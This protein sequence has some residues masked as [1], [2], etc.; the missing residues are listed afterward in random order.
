MDIYIMH[1]VSCLQ[2]AAHSVIFGVFLG[3][4]AEKKKLRRQAVC[5]LWA[6]LI[7]GNY[8]SAC[9]LSSALLLKQAAIILFTSFVMQYRF[10]QRFRRILA[11]MALYQAVNV[12]I[13]YL[14]L[15]LAGYYFPIFK[16]RMDYVWCGILLLQNLIV[17]CLVLAVKRFF[18]G[19][20]FAREKSLLTD[21]EWMFFSV[22]PLFTII[23]VLLIYM[24]FGVEQIP[25][26]HVLLCIAC[27]LAAMNAVVFYLL[28]GIARRER[29]IAENRLFA[30]RMESQ[31]REYFSM[32]ENYEKQRKRAHEFKNHM[33]VIL[34]LAKQGEED[35]V[36][37]QKKL[38]AYLEKMQ[39]ENMERMDSIDT[40]HTLL[41]A[42]LNSKYQEA[43]NKGIVFVIKI[44]DLSGISISDED[45]VVILYNLLN[46]AFEACEK[47]E[48]KIIR[49][50]F[51]QERG[52]ILLSVMNTCNGMPV[53]SGGRF[54]TEKEDRASH[55][56]GIENIK[57]VV[58]KYGGTCT[59]K[60]EGQM[61]KF[62]I[63]IPDKNHTG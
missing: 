24:N 10:R 8:L 57:E 25:G 46:N 3:I 53:R 6:G 35:G 50:K 14:E 59:I 16:D 18:A 30:Q 29:Q 36:K 58:E 19:E 31:T 62:I 42:I 40:N 54:L 21:R 55:G 27:G 47:C 9:F 43:K 28:N 7:L 33:S 22:F 44:N 5:A 34:A 4:F 12:T 15:V 41:N 26:S 17:L 45:L 49:M 1:A 32:L 56:I 48:K 52:E 63:L 39:E 37:T 61:F 11:L 60:C 51:V 20:R 2:L 38:K 23:V 13:E